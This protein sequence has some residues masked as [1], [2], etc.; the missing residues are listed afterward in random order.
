MS[1]NEI[2]LESKQL[3]QLDSKFMQSH[4]KRFAF[5]N[6]ESWLEVSVV[7]YSAV[8]AAKIR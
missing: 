7:D 4:E 6:G 2:L 3:K 5:N 8:G 1:L